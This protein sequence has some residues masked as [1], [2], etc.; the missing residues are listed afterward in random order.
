MSGAHIAH[1]ES[2]RQR[3]FEVYRT[4]GIPETFLHGN[5]MP[6][7]EFMLLLMAIQERIS[8]MNV[9]AIPSSFNPD[10]PTL[11]A[12]PHTAKLGWNSCERAIRKSVSHGVLSRVPLF[13][14]TEP[15]LF[16]A[17]QKAGALVLINDIG[18]MPLGAA[19]I[20]DAEIDAIVTDSNDAL[21]FS[22]YL[23]KSGVPLGRLWIIV[24]SPD[25]TVWELP[26]TLRDNPVKVAQEIHL[27]PGVTVLEQCSVL[28][29]KKESHF[30]V[31][32]GY[33]SEHDGDVLILSGCE[34]APLP[35]L[36][37]ELPMPM[38]IRK[39]CTCGKTVFSV[40]Q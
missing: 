20:R 25:S 12:F 7:S 21:T 23:A 11:M 19:A 39:V 31:S 38:Q 3:I 34:D 2:S 15:N 27:F 36:R 40:G 10:D 6:S 5:R 24:H 13:W 33:E 29:N 32:D 37:Y 8:G 18:N 14:Q 4:W 30:H 22:S 16:A 35:L 28:Q 1:T 26:G 17:C 9:R